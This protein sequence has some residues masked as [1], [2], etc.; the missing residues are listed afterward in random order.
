MR[1]RALAPAAKGVAASPIRSSVITWVARLRDD[2]VT[3]AWLF[4]LPT[5]V[6]LTC[7]VIYPFAYALVLTLQDK[8]AGVPGRFIGL[9]N[10]TE[11]LAKPEFL[12]IFKNTVVYTVAAVAIKF[13]VGLA[14]ALILHQPRPFNDVLRT[15][16]FVPWAIPT[17]IAALNWRWVYEEFNGMLNLILLRLGVIDVPVA[18][19]AEP[20]FAMGAVVAVA[21]WTGTPFYSMHFLAGLQAIPKEHYEAAEIDG[22]SVWQRFVHVTLPGLQHVFAITVMLSTVFTSTG[23]VV[24]N[25]LT[26]GAPAGRTQILPNYGYAMAT[27]AGRLG[28]GSAINVVFLPLLVILVFWLTRRLLRRATGE[29]ARLVGA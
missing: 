4:L 7:V 2:Q 20:A 28:M 9:R 22:A 13:V 17:V 18:W 26:N 6:V 29:P 5:G 15:I 3:I 25:V 1:A 19:L 24:V 21:V 14:T 27:D 23:I 12:L 8:A 16:L 10:F 11:L